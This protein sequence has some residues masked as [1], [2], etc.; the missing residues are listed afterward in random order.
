MKY[1]YPAIF[2]MYPLAVFAQ[3]APAGPIGTTLQQI[4]SI[5][6]QLVPLL[7]ALAVLMFFWGI[8][9]FIAGIGNEETREGGK[10][11]MVWGMIALFVMVGFWSIIGYVQESLGLYG[12]VTGG[13]APS[14]SNPIPSV[15]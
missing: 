14:L 13:V 6:T 3:S 7:M 12:T 15:L 4:F 11:L 1:I 10:R 2:L 5:V 9:K 8:V